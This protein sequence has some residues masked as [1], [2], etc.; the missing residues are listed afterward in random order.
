[1]INAQPASLQAISSVKASSSNK[2]LFPLPGRVMVEVSLQ[3]PYEKDRP[4]ACPEEMFI[5][6]LPKNSASL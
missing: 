2:L 3:N 1:L 5:D 4:L 6:T